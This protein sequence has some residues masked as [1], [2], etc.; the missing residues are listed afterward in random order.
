[1]KRIHENIDIKE[2]MQILNIEREFYTKGMNIFRRKI[3][4]ID[5]LKRKIKDAE[6]HSWKYRVDKR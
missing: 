2:A 5:S 6:K 4:K 1:M 3:A